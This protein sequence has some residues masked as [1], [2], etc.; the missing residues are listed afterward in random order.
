M[1]SSEESKQKF[2]AR[3]EIYA[4]NKKA[5]TKPLPLR[6]VVTGTVGILHQFSFP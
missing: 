2:L 3:P 1:M 4:T 5:P 6:V